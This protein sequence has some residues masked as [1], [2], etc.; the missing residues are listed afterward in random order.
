MLHHSMT[1]LHCPLF[2]TQEYRI[3]QNLE[4]SLKISLTIRNYCYVKEGADTTL[5]PPYRIKSKQITTST[6]LFCEEARQGIYKRK[7]YSYG[8]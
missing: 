6:L 2:L 8:R 4:Q 1:F 7:A 5:L 3:F